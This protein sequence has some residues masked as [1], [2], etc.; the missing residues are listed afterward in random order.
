[1]HF[2]AFVRVLLG[3]LDRSPPV[4]LLPLRRFNHGLRAAWVASRLLPFNGPR[5][6][7]HRRCF[8]RKSQAYLKK[9]RRSFIDLIFPCQHRTLRFWFN[10][11]PD[12]LPLAYGIHMDLFLPQ[13]VWNL[14][15]HARQ[16]CRI[17]V[18]SRPS[19]FAFC[20]GTWNIGL[21]HLSSVLVC[22]PGR[23]NSPTLHTATRHPFSH[24]LFLS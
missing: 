11:I 4:L 16:L 24:S 12:P 5:Y 1:M 22:L 6:G 23:K 7:R 13:L 19:M 8:S 17:L 21:D 10:L 3:G 2:Q 15:D 9:K 18:T 14:S 20:V